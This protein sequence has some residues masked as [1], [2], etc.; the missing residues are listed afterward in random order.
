MPGEFINKKMWNRYDA[1]SASIVLAQHRTVP[2]AYLLP[3]YRESHGIFR[4]VHK[5]MCVYI[6]L[7]Q[8]TDQIMV[9]HIN[10]IKSGLSQYCPN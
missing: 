10:A 5:P 3:C 9:T 7:S 4:V 8:A 2:R 6:W 1:G